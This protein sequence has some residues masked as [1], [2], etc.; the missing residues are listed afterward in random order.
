MKDVLITVSGVSEKVDKE[1]DT[2][3]LC[4]QRERPA[5]KDGLSPEN[6]EDEVTI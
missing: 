4:L 1:L 2:K 6:L 3:E 5:T